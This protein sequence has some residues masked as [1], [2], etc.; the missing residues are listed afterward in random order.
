SGVHTCS[1]TRSSAGTESYARDDSGPIEGIGPPWARGTRC[2]GPPV[3]AH[4]ADFH[5]PVANTLTFAFRSLI[6]L[7]SFH[8]ASARVR[9]MPL[10]SAVSRNALRLVRVAPVALPVAR[11]SASTWARASLLRPARAY[12]T[13]NASRTRWLYTRCAPAE[14]SVRIALMRSWFAASRTR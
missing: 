13:G 10:D 1:S 3:C 14:V 6:L 2:A 8:S 11:A 12:S 9:A 7:S 4:G 5:E